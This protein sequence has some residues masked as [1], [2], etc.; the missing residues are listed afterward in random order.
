MQE[1]LREGE[2]RAMALGNRGPIR[3]DA[4]GALDPDIRAAFSRC[5][6]YVFE[7]VLGADELADIE[8]DLHDI[9]GTPAGR[10]GLAGGCA[11]PVRAGGRLRGA[12]AVL[13]EAAWGPFRR[14]RSGQQ[15]ASGEDDRADARGR[16]PDGGRLSHPRLAPVLR[17][18]APRLRP[19]EAARGRG[20]SQRRGL[21][22][23]QRG[24]V[25]QGAR[26]G[27]LGRVAPGRRHPLG[28]PGL[29]RG[30]PRLQLHGPALRQHPRQRG[31]DRPR[32]PP[33]GKGGHPGDDR[34]R[35]L[36]TA[37]GRGAHRLQAGRRGDDQPPGAARLVR[38][39]EPPTGG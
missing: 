29:G 35:G 11:G 36:R 5:G 4:D 2:E 15:P 12:D 9:L 6:F 20:R 8:A 39:H 7:D 31:V 32:H 14:H 21:R 19:P 23:V 18:G 10:E 26:P 34:R 24:A 28:Q 22:A 16:C 33:A 3:F 17:R 1:Y 27:R 30:Q 13:V 37:A 25:H 38:E